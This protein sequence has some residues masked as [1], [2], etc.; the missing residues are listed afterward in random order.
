MNLDFEK[1]EYERLWRDPTY[2]AGFDPAIVKKFRQR[3]QQIEAAIDERTF[4]NMKS[5]HF[6][7]LSGNR[8]GQYSMRLNMQWRL[9]LKIEENNEGK[10]VVIVSIVDY[11]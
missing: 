1:P 9:I 5:L 10:L 7:K 3:V 4:Y 8:T 11:H 6:E 2:N